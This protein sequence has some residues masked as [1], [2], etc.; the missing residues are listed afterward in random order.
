MLLNKKV[1][2]SRFRRIIDT[3][4]ALIF[5]FAYKSNLIKAGNSWLKSDLS[6]FYYRPLGEDGAVP[7]GAKGNSKRVRCKRDKRHFFT[8]IIIIYF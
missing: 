8:V 3:V 4:S 5:S 1:F 2:K 6:H 7:L